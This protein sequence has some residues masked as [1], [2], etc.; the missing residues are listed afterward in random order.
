MELFD[1]EASAYT[2]AVFQSKGFDGATN[3]FHTS[4][5]VTLKLGQALTGISI[6]DNNGSTLYSG[7]RVTIYGVKA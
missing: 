2:S 1:P 4:G 6:T 7:A 5:G 3:G